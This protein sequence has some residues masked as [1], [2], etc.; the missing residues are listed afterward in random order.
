M[1]NRVFVYGT[2]KSP[3]PNTHSIKGKLLHLGR[4]PGI[5]PGDADVPG[6]VVEVSDE[7]LASLDRYEDVPNLYTRETTVANPIGEGGGEGVEVFFYQFA[8]GD[9]GR[10]PVIDEWVH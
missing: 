3:G 2:L 8:E 6:Q 5:V 7:R 10:Y 4:F 9:T 1:S